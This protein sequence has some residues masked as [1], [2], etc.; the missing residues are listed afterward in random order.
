MKHL[1]IVNP[2]AGKS[3]STEE[4]TAKVSKLLSPEEY[5]IY[6]TKKKLDAVD[7][8]RADAKEHDDLRVYACGGD[9]TLNECV[10]GAALLP[11]V[12]VAAYPCGTGNDFIKMFGDEKDRFFDLE[13]L[14]KGEV[15][16]TDLIECNG[17]YGI[18]ICSVGLDAEIG[19]DVHR[20]SGLPLIGGSFAYVVS[21]CVNVFKGIARPMRISCEGREYDGE[22]TL[23][24]VCN[25]SYYGGG[26]HPV[27]EA[28]PDDGKLDMLII[29]KISIFQVPGLIGK[30]AA[31]KY[32]ELSKYIDYI[33]GESIHIEFDK[34]YI[35]GMDGEAEMS[36]TAD[37][38]V[39]PGG[40]RCIYPRGMRFFEKVREQTAVN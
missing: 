39:V 19:A 7:K 16:P 4:I 14:V 15:H 9:G 21:V 25:G 26:F 28:R 1:F 20:Y 31:G 17:R 24:C 30:F 29:K 5:E 34:E 40:V 22:Y 11:N 2:T 37:M 23:A 13:E 3:D 10:N 33:K 6:R 32:A 27:P 38:R 35:V 8:I 36:K 18:N 12:S